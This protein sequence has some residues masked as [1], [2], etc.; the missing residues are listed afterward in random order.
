MTSPQR[1]RHVGLHGNDLVINRPCC[2]N[3][4]R[5]SRRGFWCCRNFW[6]LWGCCRFRD[7][8][9]CWRRHGWCFWN[10]WC[11][12]GFRHHFSLVKC[13]LRGRRI[14]CV[15]HWCFSF[16]DWLFPSW[17]GRPG[18]I[19]CLIGDRRRH[20]W[21]FRNDRCCWRRHIVSGHDG[22]VVSG[23][24]RINGC[25][26][27]RHGRC[28]FI[29]RYRFCRPSTHWCLRWCHTRRRFIGRGW[30]RQCYRRIG[31]WRGGR[32]LTGRDLPLITGLRGNPT[33]KR[34]R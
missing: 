2:G 21:R 32:R 11:I 29:S 16:P 19:S 4:S 13:R 24:R 28:T 10:H 34:Q 22:G 26:C 6:R 25:W 31:R 9:C 3:R 7:Y 23:R 8:R 18:G 17:T 33:A 5:R 20:H 15:R 12:W 14:G 30:C 27:F 1:M